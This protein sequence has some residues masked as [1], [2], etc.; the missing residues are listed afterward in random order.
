MPLI[1]CS[2]CRKEVSE[3]AAVCPNCGAPLTPLPESV[4]STRAGGAWSGIGFALVA[5]GIVIGLISNR[6][7]GA[8][9]ALAG[10]LV[11][12]VGRKK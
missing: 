3:E 7:L 6:L 11:L 8:L 2:G 10:A 12:I 1:Q 4:R 9:V 5:L